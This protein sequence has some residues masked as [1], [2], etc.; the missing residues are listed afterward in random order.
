MAMLYTDTALETIDKETMR[1]YAKM[2]QMKPTDELS[3][4][5]IRDIMYYLKAF[6]DEVR[7]EKFRRLITRKRSIDKKA[8]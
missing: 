2:A 6:N 5:D 3:L 1:L 7:S 4:D 8:L